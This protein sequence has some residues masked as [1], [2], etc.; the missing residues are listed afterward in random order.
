MKAFIDTI[1]PEGFA[2]RFETP[3]ESLDDLMNH[4]PALERKLS[5]A[6]YL[7]NATREWPK[8]PDGTPICPKHG[9][10]MR[11]REKQG[12]TWY[13]HSIHDPATGKDEY[14]RGYADK[15]SPGWNILT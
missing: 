13:S 9:T 3:D 6:G 2:I 1:S 10:V 12:D 5:A 7:P 4:L 15:S 14:C 11:L 8:T